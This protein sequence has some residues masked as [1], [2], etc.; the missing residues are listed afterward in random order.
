MRFGI[1]DLR[2]PA[3]RDPYL[4]FDEDLRAAE[5][6]SRRASSDGFVEA[7]RAYYATNTR[8][9][10]AQAAR[11][12]A[13]TLGAVHRSRAV[14]ADWFGTSPPEGRLVLIDAGCG[15]GPLLAVLPPAVTRI[16]IDIG[17]RWLVLAAARLR[18]QD[19]P[20]VLC[21]ASAASLA[22]ADASVDGVAAESLIENMPPADDLLREI[23]RVLRPGGRVLLTTANRHSLGPDPH[24]GLPLG[25]WVPDG[26]VNAWARRR[27]MV[28]P[29]RQLLTAHELETALV[30][31][32]MAGVRVQPAPIPAG[33]VRDGPGLLRVA[34]RVYT[35]AAATTPGRL[36]LTRF[37]PGIVVTATRASGT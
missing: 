35:G 4:S 5:H 29:R 36:F 30:R 12:I 2:Q 25:G 11:F 7:L 13:G 31:H 26:I 22:V 3:H 16:G 33:Q 18:E 20:A 14:V 24:V 10:A 34:Q 21:C 23:G 6:L 28:P 17:L 32:G 19:V 37:G 9:P 15:T 27:G 8:V 1:P